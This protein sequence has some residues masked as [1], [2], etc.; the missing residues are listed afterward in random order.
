MSKKTETIIG[1][2]VTKIRGMTKKEK[3]NEDWDNGSKIIVLELNTG[4]IIFASQDDEGNGPGCLFGQDLKNGKGI[5][6][7]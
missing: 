2:V 1:S 7:K 4:Q 3:E 6:F 5:I